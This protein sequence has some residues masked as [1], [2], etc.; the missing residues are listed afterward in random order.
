MIYLRQCLYQ[1]ICN[2]TAVFPSIIAIF[3]RNMN[4]NFWQLEIDKLLRKGRFKYKQSYKNKILT[5][6]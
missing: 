1:N 4:Y 3:N 6:I 5:Q 2:F